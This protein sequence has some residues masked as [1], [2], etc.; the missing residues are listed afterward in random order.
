MR[1]IRTLTLLAAVAGLASCHRTPLRPRFENMETATLLTSA[2]GSCQVDYLFVSIG[3]AARSQALQSIEE[4]N[5]GYFFQLE[6]FTGEAREAIDASLAEIEKQLLAPLPGGE[7]FEKHLYEYEISAVAEA[8]LADT[9]LTYTIRRQGY[10]GGAHGYSTTEFHTY[11]IVDGSELALADLFAPEQ[12]TAL[13]TQ[14]RQKLYRQYDATDDDRLAALGLFPDYIA[15]TE[16]FRIEPDGGLTLYY[17]PYD[18]ACYA[19][20][21]VELRF[22]AEEVAGLR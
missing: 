12:L 2:E 21:P 5:V 4:A 9:L 18:I 8:S 15:P 11:S 17:N 7:E 6:E 16:N 22:T 3:N 10:T 20:G 14:I 13:T 1:I 19:F